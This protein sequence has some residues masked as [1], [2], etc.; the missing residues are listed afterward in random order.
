MGKPFL[1]WQLERL[2]ERAKKMSLIK[3]KYLKAEKRWLLY[4]QSCARELDQVDTEVMGWLSYTGDVPLCY[5]CDNFRADAVSPILYQPGPYWLG[6]WDE[7]LEL[8]KW[9]SIDIWGEL[10]RLEKKVELYQNDGIL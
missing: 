3:A 5:D 8:Y 10:L 4:C 9:V 2:P 1:L 6:F 7:N